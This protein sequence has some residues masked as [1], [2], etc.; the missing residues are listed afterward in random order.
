LYKN[1]KYDAVIREATTYLMVK[2]DETHVRFMR[3]KSYRKKEMF[4]EAINDLKYNVYFYDNSYSLVSLYYLYYYLNM[5]KEALELVPKLC[6]KK[7]MHLKSLIIS[8]TVMRKQLG[9]K[10]KQR[11]D[12]MNN[13]V[14][15]QLENYDEDAA[16]LHIITKHISGTKENNSL[17]NENINIKYLF[18]LLKQNT[19]R[20]KKANIEEV[21]EVHFFAIPNI[22]Y[23]NNS[24]CNFI[25]VV[26]IPNTNN[27]ISFYPETNIYDADYT[28]LEYD[29][30]KLINKPKELVKTNSRIDKF[31]KR[32]KR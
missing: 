18:D 4:K 30:D 15:Q 10:A 1:K 31:N 29:R 3:A 9:L 6:Q 17:F 5:Y 26:V 24:I 13:Y 25:K 28:I 27:I 21:L 32:Y 19:Y 11:P 7:C 22:G 12:Y 16:L 8:E 14:A 2:P 20:S 23:D